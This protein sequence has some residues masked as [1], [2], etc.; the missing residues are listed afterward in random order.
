MHLF[1]HAPI[2]A[3]P[4]LFAHR[5]GGALAPENTLAGLEISRQLGITAVECDVKLSADGIPLLFH[6]EH[7]ERTSNGQGLF[8]QQDHVALAQLDA[9][10]WFHPAFAHERIPTLAALAEQARHHGIRVN[11]EIKPC[12]GREQET[13]RIVAQQASLL[14]QG[15]HLLPMLS[16]FS[17]AALLAAKAAAP[18]LPRAL[19]IENWP[20]DWPQ[21]VQACAACALNANERDLSQERVLAVRHAGLALMAWTVNQ[22]ARAAELYGWGTDMLC[23]DRPERLQAIAAATPALR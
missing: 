3:W 8:A 6:D 18:D 22:P 17:L 14:W 7:L 9:G 12:P 16:S 15:E 21:Q 13:G 11:L 5:L 1:E 2:Q 19:L 10:A 4:R 20:D 23:S